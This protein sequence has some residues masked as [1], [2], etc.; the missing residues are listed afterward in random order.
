MFRDAT[1]RA[2]DRASDAVRRRIEM[3]WQAAG[4]ER[5]VWSDAASHDALMAWVSHA[6]QLVATALGAVL[7]EHRIS[8]E[9]VGS[10]A[11][12]MTRLAS[13][14]PAVWLPL[15]A[16]A[17][18]ETIDAVRRLTSTLAELGDAVARRDTAA[19]ARVWERARAWRA[20]GE[21]K[22]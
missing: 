16:H 14:D 22:S 20:T 1:V 18:E 8:R 5:V 12:D 3:V 11:K 10:G 15:I 7:A 2:E 17:P 13:S 21:K 9:D 4:A 6:P 19:L